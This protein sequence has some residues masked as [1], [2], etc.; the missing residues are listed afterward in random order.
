MFYAWKNDVWYNAYAY[1]QNISDLFFIMFAG[2]G[3]GTAIIIGSCLG[4]GDFEAA[5]INADRMKGLGVMM[6]LFF[7]GLM[8]LTKPIDSGNVPS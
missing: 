2:L 5:K 3:N 6:G 4:A 7:G 8:A 1:S